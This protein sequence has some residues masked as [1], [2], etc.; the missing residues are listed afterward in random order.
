MPVVLGREYTNILMLIYS[1]SLLPLSL[2]LWLFGYCSVVYAVMAVI[3]GLYFEFVMVQSVLRSS[4][5]GKAFG[6]SIVYILTLMA[7]LIIDVSLNPATKMVLANL[8]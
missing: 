7:S 8:H 2:S 3:V 4:N 5:Y 1:L 6:V